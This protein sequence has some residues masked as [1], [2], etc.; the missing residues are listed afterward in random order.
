[1]Q[2]RKILVLASEPMLAAF[3]GMM[4]ELD[5]Y[6]PVFAEPGENAED[7]LTRVR[8]VLV[9]LLHNE[10]DAARSDLFF[11]RASR[12]GAKIVLFGAAEDLGRAV[13]EL[14]RERRL[15]F[16]LM[17]VERSVLLSVINDAMRATE[18]ETPRFTRAASDRRV[19]ARSYD[20]EDGN[21][22]FSDDTGHLW[23]VYD[24]RATER[25]AHPVD[26]TDVS[27]RAFI[28]DSGEEKRYRPQHRESIEL[29]LGALSRQLALATAPEAGED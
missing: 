11:A 15:P 13:G 8:P 2:S 29:S 18:R 21:L 12:A 25:R 23:H 28:N 6:E 19:A 16:F 3:L 1:M 20:D 14:A 4:L 22:V 26:M 10:I 7:A 27:Y 17:P 5:A 24:R 9:I